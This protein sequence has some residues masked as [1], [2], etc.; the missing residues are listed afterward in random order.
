MFILFKILHFHIKNNVNDYDFR[1]FLTNCGL[2]V[3]MIKNIL[4]LK[5]RWIK[6]N[7]E[8]TVTN[9][10]FKE[11]CKTTIANCGFKYIFETFKIIVI[12]SG[13][14]HL[15]KNHVDA[16]AHTKDY[17]DK[18]FLNNALIGIIM[19]SSLISYVK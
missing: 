9:C 15:K 11:N 17:S 8:T 3:I 2:I 6:N 16:H 4:P 18:Y 10:G 19:P 14:L 12:K 7:F 5:W 1:L 13:F